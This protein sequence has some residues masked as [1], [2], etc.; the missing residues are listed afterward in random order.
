[1]KI[2]FRNIDLPNIKEQVLVPNAVLINQ[3]TKSKVK[4]LKRTMATKTRLNFLN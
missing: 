2:K 4:L 1:M 3:M